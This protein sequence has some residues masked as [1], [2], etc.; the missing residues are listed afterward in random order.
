MAA[1]APIQVGDPTRYILEE[2]TV[3]FLYRPQVSAAQCMALNRFRES[4]LHGVS[5]GGSMCRL[6]GVKFI[7]C[8]AGRQA[9]NPL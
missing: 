9:Q 7:M 3:S 5:V 8:F 4:Q 2:G 6:A 1:A